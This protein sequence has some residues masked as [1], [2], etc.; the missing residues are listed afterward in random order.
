MTNSSPPE[1]S[2]RNRKSGL[3]RDEVIGVVVAFAT[4]GSVLYLGMSPKDAGWKFNLGESSNLFGL[5][6]GDNQS[7][8]FSSSGNNQAGNLFRS[9]PNLI[10][11]EDDGKLDISASSSVLPKVSADADKLFSSDILPGNENNNSANQGFSAFPGLVGL[12]GVASLAGSQYNSAPSTTETPEGDTTGETGDGASTT[13][14]T[15]EGDTTAG[16]TGDGASTTAET[17]EGD[18]TAGENG[19]GASTTAET[20]EGDTTA[21]ENGDGA[22]TTAETPEGDTTAGENGDGASTTAETPEDDTTTEED[23]PAKVTFSDV[24]PQHWAQ[25]FITGLAAKKIVSGFPD[26]NNFQPDEP[27]TRA[28][29]ARYIEGAGAFDRPKT[30]N[31]AQFPDI[32][33][34][35]WAVSSIDEAVSTGFMKGYSEG[36]FQPDQRIPRVQALVALATGLELK[37]KQN[38]DQTLQRFQDQD[39]IPEWARSQVAAATEAGLV[40]N[41][42]DLQ[43]LNPNQPA[44]RAEVAAMIYQ[45]LV[46]LGKVQEA[47]SDY[48]VRP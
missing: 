39:Q 4:I 21:G 22:S 31:T 12:G 44:T 3:R 30:S 26:S 35:H 18:T 38:P 2:P 14:E 29:L 32:P 19:D 25:P 1:P 41:Y 5:D 8:I 6:Q 37:P 10:G 11:E 45:A 43:A 36:N 34:D 46:R 7:G 28:Q 42:P 17:P 20:P 33:P 23:A 16:E 47:P 13:A 40:V 27:V 24:A 9:S 15:P 48:I